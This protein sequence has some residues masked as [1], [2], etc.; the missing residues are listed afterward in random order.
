MVVGRRPTP[1]EPTEGKEERHAMSLTLKPCASMGVGIGN[2][3]SE[4]LLG[5]TGGVSGSSSATACWSFP[6]SAGT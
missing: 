5:E 2:H 1:V 4:M 6:A 3:T